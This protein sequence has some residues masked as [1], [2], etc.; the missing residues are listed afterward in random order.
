MGHCYLLG[1]TPRAG[2][3]VL[4]VWQSDITIHGSNLRNFLLM[5]ISDLLGLDLDH[6]EAENLRVAG[7]TDESIAAIPFWGELMLGDY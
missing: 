6:D 1:D 5:D 4:S 7:I 3:P 2:N